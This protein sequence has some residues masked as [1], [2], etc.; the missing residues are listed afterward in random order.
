MESEKSARPPAIVSFASADQASRRIAGVAAVARVARQLVEAGPGPIWLAVPGGGPLTQAAMADLDRLVGS[1]VVQIVDKH[2]LPELID[3]YGI[4]AE[5]VV[6]APEMRA[7][8]ILKATGKASDG[9][10][11]RWLNRPISRA[12]SAVLLRLPGIRPL[13]ATTGTALIA[14]SMFTALMLGGAPGL[15]AGGLLFHAASVFDGVDGEIARATFRTSRA[16][17]ALDSIVDIATNI[18]FIAGV[19]VNLA[20][21]GIPNALL[22]GGWGLA[23]FLF[24]L[25]AMSLVAA[26]DEG[27]FMLDQL[28]QLHRGRMSRSVALLARWATIV[29][30]RDFFALLFALLILAGRPIGILYIFAAAATVWIAV[31]IAVAWKRSSKAERSA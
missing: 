16:G 21:A 27:Q 30:S 12:I 24:G 18:A 26:R 28:K 1:E 8:A 5:A 9:P 15:I 7:S 10:V 6:A 2:L 14:L 29:S 11:S 4:P 22:A 17:A 25:L 3:Q 31:V 23:L 19:A 13:H 20:A